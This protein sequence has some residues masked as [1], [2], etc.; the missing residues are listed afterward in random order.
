MGGITKIHQRK[1]NRVKGYNYSQDGMYFIT[2]CTE[3][4]ENLFGEV[5]NDKMILNILLINSSHRGI[6][7]PMNLS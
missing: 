2:I 1:L 4:R 7:L 3:N 6:I 5:A